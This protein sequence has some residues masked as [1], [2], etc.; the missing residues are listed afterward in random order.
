MAQPTAIELSHCTLDLTRHVIRQ[1]EQTAGL[2]PMETKLLAYLSDRA[3]QAIATEE[4]LRN[5][6]GYAEGVISRAVHY[7]VRRLRTKIELDPSKPAHLA[8]T[9]LT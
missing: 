9:R 7:T 3:G 5:V 1:G 4:L 2:T 6:W 8:S